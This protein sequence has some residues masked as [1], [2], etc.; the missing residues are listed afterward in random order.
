MVAYCDGK[1]VWIQDTTL[2]GK[3]GSIYQ[4]QNAFSLDP[5]IHLY[6]S[7]CTLLIAPILFLLICTDISGFNC[8]FL[9]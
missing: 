1:A 9:R 3:S 7:C 5:V 2:G 8:N 4:S 6:Y